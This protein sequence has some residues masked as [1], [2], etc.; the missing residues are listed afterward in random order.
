MKN[1]ILKLR[2]NDVV[3]GVAVAIFSAI[4]AVLLGVVNSPGFDLFHLDWSGLLTQV[5][6]VSVAAFFGYLGKNF[7]STDKGSVLNLTPE[8]SSKAE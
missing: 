6:N 5:L 4:F 3:K 1:G 2:Q 7:F 8:D